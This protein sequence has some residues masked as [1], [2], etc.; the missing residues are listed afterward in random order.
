MRKDRRRIARKWLPL[1]L[2]TVAVVGA[3]LMIFSRDGLPRL[4]AVER[5]LVGVESENAQLEREIG[6]LRAT[7]QRLRDDPAT[8]ERLARDDLGLIRQNEVI[9][10]FP[11]P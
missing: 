9:F 5:E 11:K 1:G 6:I 4:R 8:L 10:Q 3:P 7:V 2:L